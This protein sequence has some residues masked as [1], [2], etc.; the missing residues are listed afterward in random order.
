M[1]L[2]LQ[3]LLGYY[4]EVLSPGAVM[5]A[6]TPFVNTGRDDRY[7]NV[8]TEVTESYYGLGWRIIK[9]P[10]QNNRLPRRTGK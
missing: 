7:F 5:L 10:P 4:P 1:Q 8:W 2:W 6:F 3:A 9:T